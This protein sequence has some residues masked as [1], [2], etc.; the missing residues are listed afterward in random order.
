MNFFC[1]EDVAGCFG[2]G[3]GVLFVEMERETNSGENDGRRGIDF[4]D[5]LDDAIE[6][7]GHAGAGSFEQSRGARA[8]ANDA[9]AARIISSGELGRAGAVEKFP[10]DFDG[11][12]AADLALE[13]MPFQH[14]GRRGSFW[15]RS[16]TS[17]V[18]FRGDGARC[19]ERVYVEW[20]TGVST[21][22]AHG[23]WV[24]R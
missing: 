12:G 6:R 10:A 22:R 19:N 7:E 13:A 8:A 14:G 4:A 3:L 5:R 18:S 23:G 20:K 11:I 1:A 2:F 16:S 17:G 21:T 9:A 15:R 24:R